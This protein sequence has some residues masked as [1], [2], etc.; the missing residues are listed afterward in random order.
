MTPHTVTG[1]HARKTLRPARAWALP[2]AASVAGDSHLSGV[3]KLLT[4]VV[5]RNAG[6]GACC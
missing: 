2:D 1:K 5:V 3:V 6:A 4:Y